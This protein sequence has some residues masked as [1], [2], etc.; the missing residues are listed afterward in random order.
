MTDFDGDIGVRNVEGFEAESSTGSDPLFSP[1]NGSVSARESAEYSTGGRQ[2][3]C[4][5]MVRSKFHDF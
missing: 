4:F 2:E 3:I 1:Y 5:G